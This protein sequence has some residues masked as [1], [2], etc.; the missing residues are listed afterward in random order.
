V[1]LAWFLDGARLVASGVGPGEHG[2]KSGIWIIN[3]LTATPRQIRGNADGAV[4]SP[5]GSLV[6]FHTSSGESQVAVVD[7]SG[8]N[9]RVLASAAL[10]ETFG[11][12]QWSPDGKKLA[13]VVFHVGDP[14][15]S[16]DV[17]DAAGGK[18]TELTRQEYLRTFVWLRDGR[19]VFTQAKPQYPSG[20]ALHVLDARGNDRR[21]EI[22][23]GLG[24]SQMSATQDDK[25]LAIIRA[26]KQAD[27]YAAAIASD[28]SIN[29]PRRITLDDRD[30]RPT[31]WM[32]GGDTL[33]FE[34]NRNGT[35]DVFRQR[36]EAADAEQVA[37][38]PGEQ[39]AGQ[40]APGG[41][42][43]LYWS[44]SNGAP[45]T[46]LMRVPAEGGPPTV[47]LEAANNAEFRCASAA[48]SP[49]A[50]CVLAEF[51]GQKMSVTSFD[52]RNGTRGARQE[53]P[54]QVAPGE[55]PNWALSPDA[56]AVAVTA[57]GAV[58]VMTIGAGETWSAPASWFSGTLTGVA[59]RDAS[60]LIVTT[61]SARENLVLLV[62]QAGARK[63]WSSPR[64]VSLP[65][66]S[67]DGKHLLVAVTT[68]SSNAWLVEDY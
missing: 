38:G 50:A 16:I 41:A 9:V 24:V 48:A 21:V 60:Q 59:F 32:P 2:E 6:A 22:G 67:P 53:L 47:V 30:D 63:I 61:A 29:E 11:K 51:E 58:R 39:F 3:V 26:S 52:W 37:G 56:R 31:G 64:M 20:A 10:N 25:K 42:A 15:T 46:R 68:E 43:V 36:L 40:S 17:I 28:G 35:W 19:I 65:V 14:K 34:S 62:K 5:D 7:T 45:E 23:A 8:E 18:R 4:P 33:L 55:H 54:V 1:N 27:V 49:D 13:F 44:S 12:I 57:G 66:I